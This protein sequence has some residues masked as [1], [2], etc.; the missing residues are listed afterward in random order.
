MR[1]VAFVAAG[2]GERA[3]GAKALLQYVTIFIIEYYI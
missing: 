1:M 3:A 2:R